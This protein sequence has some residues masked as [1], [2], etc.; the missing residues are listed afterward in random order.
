MRARGRAQRVG[1]PGGRVGV[2]LVGFVMIV[3]ARL[4][5][6]EMQRRFAAEGPGVDAHV[7]Q[8]GSPRRG[9]A[10]GEEADGHSGGGRW[11]ERAGRRLGEVMGRV[12]CAK[13]GEDRKRGGLVR[14]CC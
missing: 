8:V 1:E 3:G 4:A 9:V 12:L 6:R 5:G 13:V 7:D 2:E 11:K 10:R 14:C